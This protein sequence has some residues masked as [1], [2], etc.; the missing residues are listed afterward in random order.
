MTSVWV[1]HEPELLVEINQLVEQPLRALEVNVVIAGAV[2]DK[3]LALQAARESDWRAVFIAL[4]IFIRQ[5]HVAL[6]VDRIIQRLIR[7]RGAG[8]A[9]FE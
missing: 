3:Q 9:H 5:P 1:L 6:L 4:Y 8:N 2:D 7:D